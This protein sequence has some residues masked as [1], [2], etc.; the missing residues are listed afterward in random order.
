M[1]TN[2][3][4]SSNLIE[5]CLPGLCGVAVTRL[6]GQ[7]CP[8]RNRRECPP[9]TNKSDRQD[10]LSHTTIVARLAILNRGG[11]AG[12]VVLNLEEKKIVDGCNALW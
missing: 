10:C 2:Y 12:L 1:S 7:A 4:N 6:G 3:F 11:I 5:K 9:H 8:E